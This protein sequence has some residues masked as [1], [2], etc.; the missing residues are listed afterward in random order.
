MIQTLRQIYELSL[1]ECKIFLQNPI[2]VFCM[3]VFP[4][5]VVFF[6]TSMLEQ[7]QPQELPVGVVDLDNT[8]TTRGLIRRLDAF[9][10]SRVVAFYASPAE[11]RKAIQ[12]NEICGFLYIPE[13]TTAKLLASRQPKVSFYYSMTTLVAG[14]LV[15]RDM[16]TITRSHSNESTNR[17]YEIYMAAV[18]QLKDLLRGPVRLIGISLQ[19][20]NE[21][22]SRQ[23]TFSDLNGAREKLLSR[24]WKK[25][26][27]NLQRRY[28][29]NLF[30]GK[31]QTEWEE[32]LYDVISTMRR[33]VSIAAR[34]TI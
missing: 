18:G 31:T 25:A 6:F 26:V 27:W 28:S 7:G 22:Y 21:T 29:A 1:R 16:K 15:F 4:L 32:H 8:S 10:S 19:N 2:Y 30:V 33:R 13:G 11:A 9:Q 5:A 20:L 34:S 3:V 14:S 12:N 23:L 24:R 17:A